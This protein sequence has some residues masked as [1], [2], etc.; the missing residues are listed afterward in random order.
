[1]VYVPGRTALL[2]QDRANGAGGQSPS[3]F[4]KA[5]MKIG[6]Y[7]DHPSVACR[8]NPDRSSSQA[9]R[10]HH[11]GIRRWLSGC[12][13]SW[14]RCPLVHR[15]DDGRRRASPGEEGS[16]V[17]RLS[18]I[19]E[20]LAW[21]AGLGQDRHTSL[22]TNSRWVPFQRGRYRFRQIILCCR[23]PPVRKTRTP[24]TLP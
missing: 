3:I 10:S 11:T 7:L 8:V 9:T 5:V 12:R 24:S 17:T 14:S 19:E 16:N 20:L 2:R 18:A 21:M 4:Q 6:D 15:G 23:S 22:R 1:M 13:D